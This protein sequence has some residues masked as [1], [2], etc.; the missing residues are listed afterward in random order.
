[1][2]DDLLD[3]G[4]IGLGEQHVEADHRRA[5]AAQRDEQ[6]AHLGAWPR[7]LPQLLERRLVDVDDADRQLRIVGL[8][9]EL[10]IGIEGDQAQRAHEERIDDAHEHRRGEQREDEEQVEARRRG[11]HLDRTGRRR[12]GRADSSDSDAATVAAFAARP[13]RAGDG[14]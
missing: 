2:L 3:R 4:A 1:L 9:R 12:R 10:L 6:V 8:R 13:N 5:L 14:H 11:D 7:P